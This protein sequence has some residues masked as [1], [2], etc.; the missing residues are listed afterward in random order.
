MVKTL[1]QWLDEPV[2]VELG[3]AVPVFEQRWAA[4]GWEDVARLAEGCGLKGEPR[5]GDAGLAV[6]EGSKVL[7]A[8]GDGPAFFF[9]DTSRLGSP[10]YRPE[11]LPSL[12]EAQKTA[13]DFL[14]QRDWLPRAVVMDRVSRDQIERVDGESRTVAANCNCVDLRFKLGPLS[15][16]GPGAKIK[17]LLGERNEVIGLFHAAPELKQVA[18]VRLAPRRRLA[19]VLTAKLGVPLDQVEVR[20]DQ[21]AYTAESA[22]SGSRLVHPVYVLTLATATPSRRRGSPVSVEFMTHPLPASDAAPVIVIRAGREPLL[23]RR[24]EPLQLAAEVDG[25]VPPYTIDWRSN[26]DGP[27]GEGERLEATR[28]S[29]AHRGRRVVSHTVT[30]TV[31][32]ANG[33]RDSHAVLVRVD[34]GSS[35]RPEP[36]PARGPVPGDPFVGV[37][38]CNLYHGAP[39]LADIS[40][41]NASAQGFRSAMAALPGWS[42]RFDWGNDAAWEEDFKTSTAS[43]GGT[44]AYWADNVDLAFFAGHGSPGAFYFGSQIDDHQMVAGDARWGE[45]LL[46]WLVLHACQTMRADFGWTVWC[47]SFRGLHQM[48]GFHTNTEGSTPPL[49]SRFAYWAAAP[50]GLPGLFDLRTAWRLACTECF[51]SSVEC[52]SIY[53][54][55]AGT[56]THLD[57][58][59]GYGHVSADPASPNSWAYSR[60]TC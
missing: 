13:L 37:E 43:G 50:L 11:R 19:R 7:V 3:G 35:I 17:V 15:S 25:G 4:R 56:D 57:H 1:A 23:L 59:P 6:V 51:D 22:L 31:T 18:E 21:L 54:N 41:T 49:G 26:V 28:L 46:N 32:D 30:A 5:Q 44:D 2:P 10:D 38:W 55:G 47:D 14:R 27:L 58:L 53:A 39:G 12:R 33:S 34:P 16:Y 45:G 42:S 40:G 60:Q 24:G 52:A 36:L 8:H 9:A 20:G 48:F 29:V